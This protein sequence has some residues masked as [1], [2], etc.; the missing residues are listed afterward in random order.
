MIPFVDEVISGEPKYIITHS[1]NSTEVVSIDLYNAIT[2]I[3]TALNKIYFDSI[4]SYVDLLAKYNIPTI[5]QTATQ[6]TGNYIPSMSSATGGFSV[7]SSVSNKQ[8]NPV[9]S[10]ST[11]AWSSGST[12]TSQTTY[13]QI[14]LDS[15]IYLSQLSIKYQVVGTVATPLKVQCSYDG[16]NWDNVGTLSSTSQTT[17]T[18]NLPNNKQYK[19]IRVLNSPQTMAQSMSL[20][21][22]QITKWYTL[23]ATNIF[24]LD[25]D[26]T[27]YEQGQRVAIQV[28]SAFVGGALQLNINSLGAKNVELETITANE[29]IILVYDGTKFIRDEV[30]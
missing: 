21:Q 30:A 20:Y 4:K 16:N 27:A 13:W 18:I 29:Y 12:S 5:T 11:E 14:E 7:T 3:G 8:Y 26:L 10:S 15:L 22:V 9:N 19:Y 2:T 23:S 1:D 28:P 25:N 24:A 6:S 17:A